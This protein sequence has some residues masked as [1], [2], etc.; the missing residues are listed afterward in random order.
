MQDDIKKRVPTGIPSLDPVLDGGVPPG[1]VILLAGEPGA[2]NREF[3]YSSLLL[4]SK[5][6]EK[7]ESKPDIILPD[8]IVYTTFTRLSSS[9]TNEMKLSFKEDIVSGIEDKLNFIDLSEIYFDSSVVPTG[10]YSK[11]SVIERFQKKS[12]SGSLV[13][14]LAEELGKLPK[15]SLIVIDSITDIATES[16]GITEWK[17]MVGF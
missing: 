13:A 3:V 9:I 11:T 7:G 16:T 1:S 8:Q 17:E 10:W 6:K 2:G 14:K 15:N 5:L 12:E 4:I